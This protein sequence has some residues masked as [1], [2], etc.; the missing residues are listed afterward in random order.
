MSLNGLSAY[1]EQN[2]Q[3][4]AN[5]KG[6]E[7]TVELSPDLPP[8]IR[9]DRQRVE[10]IVKNFLSNALKFTEK[11]GITVTIDRPASGTDLSAA[12]IRS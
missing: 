8:S 2:F 12:W 5:N 9:T 1:I 11:G 6:L 10:Q 7:L 3:H 4:V